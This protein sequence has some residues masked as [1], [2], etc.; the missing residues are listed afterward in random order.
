M[1]R[2]LNQGNNSSNSLIKTI[3]RGFLFFWV[4]NAIVTGIPVLIFVWLA[5]GFGFY[6]ADRTLYCHHVNSDRA[7]C[8]IERVDWLNQRVVQLVTD[9]KKATIVSRYSDPVKRNSSRIYYTVRLI[10]SQDLTSA[11]SYSG[12]KTL[13]MAGDLPGVGLKSFSR[14]E[15]QAAEQFVNQ[16]NTF[17]EYESIQP[18]TLALQR[19]KP[20]AFLLALLG[21]G[22]VLPLLILFCLCCVAVISA[23]T[24]PRLKSVR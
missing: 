15:R 4:I 18:L 2:E 19:E 22:Y 1:S 14:N 12:G 21:V 11:G 13:S 10:S 3:A 9:A 5:S 17:I 7:N 16:I 23:L 20:S 24:R 8:Q 6:A